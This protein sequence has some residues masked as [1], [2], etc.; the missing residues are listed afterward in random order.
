MSIVSGLSLSSSNYNHALQLLQERYGN[1]QVLINAYMNKFVTIPPVKN[2]RDV[3]G[4]RKLYD[5][6]KTNV[7]NLRTLNVDTSPKGSL[8]VPLPNEN[9]SLDLRLRL[10]RNFENEVWIL[11][12]VL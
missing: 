7:R 5:E 12:N 1:T 10:S 8:L 11:N 3:R 6:V 9:L 2:D 4:L